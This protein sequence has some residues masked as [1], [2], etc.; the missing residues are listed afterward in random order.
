MRLNFKELFQNECPKCL[1]IAVILTQL[2]LDEDTMGAYWAKRLY[3]RLFIGLGF[4]LEYN[5][6]D[7]TWIKSTGI[8]K[9]IVVPEYN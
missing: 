5:D 9:P 7:G 2:I 3:C 1:E 4:E 6:S 8:K